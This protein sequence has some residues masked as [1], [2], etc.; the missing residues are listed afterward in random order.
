MEFFRWELG[1]I[2]IYHLSSISNQRASTLIKQEIE[3]EFNGTI[4]RKHILI[5][6]WKK[7]WS[8]KEGIFVNLY[9]QLCYSISVIEDVS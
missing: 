6:L 5:R 4:V 7:F 9:R 8:I 2:C 1:V 3:K